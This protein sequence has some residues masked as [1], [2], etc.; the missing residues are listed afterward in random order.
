[1][2]AAAHRPSDADL[3]ARCRRDPDAF[4][5]VYDRHAQALFDAL[6]PSCGAEVAREVVQETFARA[7]RDAGRFRGRGDGSARPWLRAIA[8][9]LVRDW[10]RRGIVEDRVRRE[11]GLGAPCDGDDADGL[12]RLEA[13]VRREEIRDALDSLP[14]AQR[15][16]VV[17]R[18]VLD[19]TYDE[20]AGAN[21]VTPTAARA[22][23]SRGLRALRLRLARF[24]GRNP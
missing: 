12:T 23:V 15:Q 22:H 8:W 9:N 11:L 5:I 6:R 19:A 17:G 3:L 1:M 24:E 2:D 18:V 20:I 13:N 21:G 10:R 4:C 7:L 14:P 16:A